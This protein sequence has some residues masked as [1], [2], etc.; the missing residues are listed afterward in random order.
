MRHAPKFPKRGVK[1]TGPSV[2]EQQAERLREQIQKLEDERL[3]HMTRL[4]T[5]PWEDEIAEEREQLDWEEQSLKSQL[6]LLKLTHDA[7]DEKRARGAYL[8]LQ[9]AE[10]KVEEHK[11][12]LGAEALLKDATLKEIAIN[13]A[14]EAVAEARAATVG[15][16]GKR[17]KQQTHKHQKRVRELEAKIDK[18]R[19]RLGRVVTEMEAKRLD[20]KAE[21]EAT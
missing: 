7:I 8:R 14:L 17:R 15:V 6:A 21:D 16:L 1:T 11:T 3:G 12:R 19:V 4:Q 20:T 10:L 13:A 2:I 5:D 9:I 18:L